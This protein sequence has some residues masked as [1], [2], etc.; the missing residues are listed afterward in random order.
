MNRF[1]VEVFH[2]LTENLKNVP[3][4]VL[5]LCRAPDDVD[6]LSGDFWRNAR[7]N[8]VT[9]LDHFHVQI[10]PKNIFDKFVVDYPLVQLVANVFDV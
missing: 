7:Q 6:M 10:G 9:L 3:L 2:Q 5:D 4:V 1:D 8:V